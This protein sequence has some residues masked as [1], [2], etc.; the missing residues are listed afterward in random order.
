MHHVG[1]SQSFSMMKRF[2]VLRRL[3]MA[4]MTGYMPHPI[5]KLVK[6]LQGSRE[7]MLWLGVSYEE[8][9][10]GHFCEKGVKTSAKVYQEI[11]LERQVKNLNNTLFHGQ[12]WSYQ[13]DSAPDVISTS[14]WHS[15]SPGL[16]PLDYKL[17]SKL[18]EM[19]YIPIL[20]V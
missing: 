15:A 12:N 1:T 13:Q 9:T 19:A 14:D 6:R 8:T 11:V 5:E 4:R 2:S 10:E 3:S 7:V 18:Q 16:N 17:W 20:K